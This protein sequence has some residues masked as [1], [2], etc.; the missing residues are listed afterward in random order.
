MYLILAVLS[1]LHAVSAAPVTEECN[2]GDVVFIIDKSGSIGSAWPLQIDALK[3]MVGNFTVGVDNYQFGA[4]T[5]DTYANEEF[6]LDEH[7]TADKVKQALDDIIY[8]GGGTKISEGF[9]AAREVFDKQGNRPGVRDIA[10]LFTDGYS[11]DAD[12]EATLLKNDDVLIITVGV[13][14]GHNAADMEKY[15]SD[16]EWYFAT[17][18]YE[19]LANILPDITASVCEAVDTPSKIQACQ[20]CQN[21]DS[22]NYGYMAHEECYK[23]Y[24]CRRDPDTQAVDLFASMQCAPG[25][26]FNYASGLEGKPCVVIS[27]EDPDCPRE[28]VEVPPNNEYTCPYV[29]DPNGEDDSF[30]IMNDG[31][32]SFLPVGSCGGG[33]WDQDLCT[34]IGMTGGCL[35]HLLLDFANDVQD[36]SCYRGWISNSYPAVE[37]VASGMYG[38][39]GQF[40]GL[41]PAAQNGAHLMSWALNGA[42]NPCESGGQDK[43]TVA[44]WFKYTGGTGLKGLVSYCGEE[45]ASFYLTFN[46]N[47]KTVLGGIDTYEQ[48]LV[49]VQSGFELESNEWYYVSMVYDSQYVKLYVTHNYNYVACAMGSS[50]TICEPHDIL[51]QTGCIESKNC[52]L[53]IGASGKPWE[54]D[55]YFMGFMDDVQ[56]LYGAHY[57]AC[58]G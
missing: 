32:G 51:P 34:C 6:L 11:S 5:F 56:I 47:T 49:Q 3:V 28:Q 44:T 55:D 24:L 16:P 38:Q 18:S 15:A 29:Q 10:V 39:G 35:C 19:T 52:G 12:D 54:E 7:D 22:D 58:R 2:K 53:Q 43:L 23:Y 36:K 26:V 17:P 46:A 21:F 27:E 41:L 57:K 37:V 30:G 40:D 50:S 48:P 45:G 8:T 20:S 4:V 13:S 42:F 33:Y 1:L 25:T 9:L 14:D 31:P